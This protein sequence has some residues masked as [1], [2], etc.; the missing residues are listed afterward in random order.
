MSMFVRTVHLTAPTITSSS[1]STQY[2][3]PVWS[4]P[5][6][7]GSRCLLQP[8]PRFCATVARATKIT[9]ALGQACTAGACTENGMPVEDAVET[10]GFRG[11]SVITMRA[12]C[13]SGRLH[14][15][16]IAQTDGDGDQAPISLAR[17][18]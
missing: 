16:T 6:Q 1:T 9:Y 12:A 10:V 15:D 14:P 5:T 4:T 17:F 7:T 2:S 18:L 8:R 3:S 11:S 13:D